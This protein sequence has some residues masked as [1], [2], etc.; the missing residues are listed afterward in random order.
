M[1]VEIFNRISSFIT[2]VAHINW[3]QS[4]DHRRIIPIALQCVF[5]IVRYYI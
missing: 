3:N 4:S 1:A 2:T 5:V